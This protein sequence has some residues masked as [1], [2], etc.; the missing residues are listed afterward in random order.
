MYRVKRGTHDAV[1]R[2]EQLVASDAVEY[3]EGVADNVD[4]VE[5]G[6]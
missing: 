2:Y 6:A 3:A 1:V 5:N 4:V